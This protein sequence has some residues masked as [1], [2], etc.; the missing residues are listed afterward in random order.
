MLSTPYS[1]LL[2]F[3]F[4][5]DAERKTFEIIPTILNVS[6]ETHRPPE[7]KQT[8]DCSVLFQWVSGVAAFGCLDGRQEVPRMGQRQWGG[9][10]PRGGRLCLGT[11]AHFWSSAAFASGGR[12]GGL[13]GGGVGRQHLGGASPGRGRS[14][15]GR[16]P[17][18]AAV[19][20]AALRPTVRQRRALQSPPPARAAVQSP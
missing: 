18:G 3:S 13:H 14:G 15:M 16:R 4:L 10:Q 19:R 11:P 8:Q 20:L 12:R 6:P 5:S 7:N 1:P 9:H 2:A 17:Q